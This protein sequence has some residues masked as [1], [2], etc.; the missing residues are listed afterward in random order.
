MIPARTKYL[1]AIPSFYF[2]FVFGLSAAGLIGP[3]EPRYA[4]IGREMAVSGDWITPRL[5]GETWFEKPPLLYW[6]AATGFRAGLGT[7]LAA[8]LPVALTGIAFLIFFFVLLRR[9]FGELPAFYST[10]ILATSAGWIAFS[11]AAATDLPLAATFGASVLLAM[12]WLRRQSKRA[13][14]GSGVLLGLAILAKG[15]VPLVLTVPLFWFGRRRVRDLALFVAVAVAAAAPWYVAVTLWHGSEFINEF[16]WKHHF[17]RFA[18]ESLQHVRPFWFYIP[19]L[20]AGIFPWTPL[21]MLLARRVD[22]DIPRRFLT[23]IVVFGFVFFSVSTNKL[24]GY[25]LPLF[26]PLCVLLGVALDE[27]KSKGR[28]QQQAI[29]LAACAALLGLVPVAGSLLPRALQSGL[30]RASWA[31]SW[32]GIFAA[33]ALSVIVWFAVSRRRSPLALSIIAVASVAGVIYLKIVALPQ[34]DRTASSRGLWLE[35]E[36]VAEFVCVAGISRSWRY[37]LNYYAGAPFFECAS[38][39]AK[40]QIV[41]QPGRRPELRRAR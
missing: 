25:L 33:L 5:W 2:L 20:L 19:V 22:R 11:H 29:L 17:E 41:Q 39:T 27:V 26:P 30:S 10:V 37:G 40:L 6:M 7:E 36:P 14:I 23:A 34:V 4:S 13:L 12:V 21:L 31:L 16:F 38:E 28:G 1:S 24:P 18:S 35:V 32:P 8:R 9:E 15:L 3:D